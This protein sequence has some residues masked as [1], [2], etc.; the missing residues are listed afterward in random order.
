MLQ[1][2][3]T[4]DLQPMGP[5]L[6]PAFR[7]YMVFLFAVCL[8]AT[9]KLI[10]LWRAA[11]PFKLERQEK[12]PA[13]FRA[14]EMSSDSL[15]QWITFTFLAWGIVASID[16]YNL[17]NSLLGD[18]AIRRLAILFAIEGFSIGLTLA[19]LV[20]LFLALI[21][22]HVLKRVEQLRYGK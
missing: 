1:A 19:L 16:L 15:R 12:N 8:L 5:A 9:S 6:S 22:W 14:L 3:S 10:K 20:V 21:R 7:L 18:K 2:A 11:P 13:Y 17:C 4:W